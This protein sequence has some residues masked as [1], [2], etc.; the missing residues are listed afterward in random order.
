MLMKILVESLL[1]ELNLKEAGSSQISVCMLLAWSLSAKGVLFRNG[2]VPLSMT[3]IPLETKR[4]ANSIILNRVL[5]TNHVVFAI[6][7]LLGIRPWR[8]S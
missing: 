5:L 8:Y 1:G 3:T 4:S 7:Q 6:L 2:Q